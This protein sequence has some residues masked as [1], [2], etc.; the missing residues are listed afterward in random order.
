MNDF[1]AKAIS[2]LS[3]FFCEELIDSKC[4]LRDFEEFVSTEGMKIL[5]KAMSLA[6]EKL[7]NELFIHHQ[8][9]LKVKE[10]RSRTL[11]STVGDLEFSRRIYVDVYGN[12]Y[13]MLDELLDVGHRAKISPRAFEFLV[14]MASKVSYQESSNILASAGGSCISANTIMRAIHKGGENCKCEDEKL[15]YSL[16]INGVLPEAR[17]KVSELFVESDGTYI[18]LQNG[19]KAEIK[20]MVAYAGKEGKKRVK[21]VNTCHFGCIGNKTAF[22]TQAVSAVAENFDLSEV[23]KVHM[24]F[25]GD[26]TYK[27]AE[28]YFLINA[29]FDGNLDPFHVNRAVGYCFKDDEDARKQVMSC[30][31]YRNPLDAADMVDSYAEGGVIKKERAEMLARYI[32]NNA[33]FIKKNNFTLGTMECEQE[34]M[35]KSRMASVPCAWSVKGAD[36]VA[37]IRSRLHSGRDLVFLT[38]SDTIPEERT[39]MREKKVY[40]F[41]EKQ[42][43][44]YQRTT[45]KGYNYP[46]QAHLN[47]KIK[48]GL[49]NAWSYYQK[50]SG[51][52]D[53]Y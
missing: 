30:L 4:S 24:G 41:L 18:S 29:E 52:S 9:S 19:K 49:V 31:W 39:E 46:C 37:R 5:C 8:S 50:K 17:S 15:A 23:K 51:V 34:H 47:Q 12:S 21:R 20:A 1:K 10:K 38:R 36:A 6:L 48:S 16:Y 32:R 3:D 27:N 28:G 2:Q 53:P 25:D 7:D 44:V 22:W 13:P 26:P 40:E 11:A 14:E 43:L 35:Y 33:E 45:G 42:P